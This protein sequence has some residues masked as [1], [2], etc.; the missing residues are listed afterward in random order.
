MHSGYK[1]A[2]MSAD[3]S[4]GLEQCI[5]KLRADAENVPG[6]KAPDYDR[7]GKFRT[8]AV[9]DTAEEL[10]RATAP[11]NRNAMNICAGKEYPSGTV[12]L[13]PG[14][15]IHQKKM[16]TIL[17]GVSPFF[18][19]RLAEL[20]EICS[21]V[22]DVRLLDEDTEY[23]LADQLRVFA[24]EVAIAEHWENIGCR[25]DSIIGH[26]M[27]EYAAAV[28]SG[29]MSERDAFFLLKER[30]IAMSGNDGHCMAAAEASAERIMDIAQA[31]GLDITISAYNAP[32][33]VTVCGIKRDMEMMSV[34]CR[35]QKIR[36]SLINGSRGGHYE[37]LKECAQEFLRKAEGIK[38]HKPEKRFISSLDPDGSE[39]SPDSPE[40]WYAHIWKP[41]KFM[42]AVG[43]LV[44]EE[45]GRVIDVGVSPVLINMVMKNL[46]NIR[47]AWI[48][49]VRAGRNYSRHI[50]HS[51]GIAFNSGINIDLEREAQKSAE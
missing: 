12:F 48:P 13:F 19:N 27:G 34:I 25:A 1:I 7:N 17:S 15:G 42:Q 3:S 33:I 30:C 37:G 36:F 10:L 22:Y 18:R 47:T 11:E 16:L 46:G 2:L 14:S 6:Y 29:I 4:D 23:E 45:T 51:A 24:S 40:Y 35:N 39:Y 21:E 50:L 49:T 28:F 32:E 43:K 9:Y 5:E 44:P 31:A 38:F 20:D 41:V 8:F 26:S